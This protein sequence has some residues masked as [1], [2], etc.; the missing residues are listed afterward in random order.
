MRVWRVNEGDVLLVNA[1]SFGYQ[2][3]LWD[4]PVKVSSFRVGAYKDRMVAFVKECGNEVFK[5]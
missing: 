4:F 1:R 2:F 5:G 3:E